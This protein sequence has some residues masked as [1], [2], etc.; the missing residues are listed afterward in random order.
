MGNLTFSTYHG[1]NS[2]IILKYTGV[3]EK[4][5]SNLFGVFQSYGDIS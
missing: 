4:Q 5:A 2:D 1:K 3:F